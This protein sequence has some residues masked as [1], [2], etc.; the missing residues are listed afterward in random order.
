LFEEAN[1]LENQLKIAQGN[2]AATL[3]AA[4]IHANVAG[5]TARQEEAKV[6][7]YMKDHPGATRSEAYAAVAQYSRGEAN[8]ISRMRYADAA[9]GDDVE[10]LKLKNSKKPEDQAKAAEIRRKT[11]ERYGVTQLNAGAA[12]TPAPMQNEDGTVT[13]PGRGTFKKLP[14]GNYAPV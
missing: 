2:N 1:K 10:Y 7:A 5:Q 14:N 13:I 4:Q 9:L 11:Y 6:D 12:A 8:D 3:G